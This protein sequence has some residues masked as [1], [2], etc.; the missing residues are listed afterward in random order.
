LGERSPGSLGEKRDNAAESNLSGGEKK[1]KV[2]GDRSE[3]TPQK[4]GVSNPLKGKKGE[5]AFL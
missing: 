3:I 1:S 5:A 2:G 4:K